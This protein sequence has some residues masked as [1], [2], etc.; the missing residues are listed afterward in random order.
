MKFRPGNPKVALL[1]LMRPRLS[2]DEQVGPAAVPSQFKSMVHQ[3]QASELSKSRQMLAV[4]RC[5][6]FPGAEM[7]FVTLAVL[8]EID[9]WYDVKMHAAPRC[10]S[11]PHSAFS[12]V[13]M[14]WSMLTAPWLGA[15]WKKEC[16]FMVEIGMRYA[17][18]TNVSGPLHLVNHGVVPRL[19][20]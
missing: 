17:S 20:C 7:G 2:R 5:T 19:C 10:S 15:R 11:C 18:H 8:V 12:M 1:T 6:S 14:T 16:H 13:R 3:D 4:S 9:V